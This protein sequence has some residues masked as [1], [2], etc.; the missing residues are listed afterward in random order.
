MLR[1]LFFHRCALRICLNALCSRRVNSALGIFA[2]SRFQVGLTLYLFFKVRRREEFV[3][4]LS[5]PCLGRKVKS[6]RR[7]SAWSTVEGRSCQSS[8][9][10]NR[11]RLLGC[12]VSSNLAG[13]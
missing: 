6:E 10:W 12:W 11:R 4:A 7:V 13:S 5:N 1:W 9:L 8:K 2:C 3:V